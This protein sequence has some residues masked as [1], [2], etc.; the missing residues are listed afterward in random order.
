M[1]NL[2]MPFVKGL[3]YA[4]YRKRAFFREDPIRCFSCVVD[5]D[6]KEMISERTKK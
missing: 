5:S 1:I 2:L 6:E 4:G 3:N